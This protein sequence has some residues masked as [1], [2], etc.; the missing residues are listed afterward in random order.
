MR[1]LN[2]LLHYDGTT[3]WENILILLAALVAGFLLH[4]YLVKTKANQQF[5]QSLKEWENKHRQ[6]ENE[7][8]A[9]KSTI[10]SSEKTSQKSVTELSGRVK[11]LEGDIRALSDEKNKYQHQLQAKEDELKKYSSQVVD[12]EDRLKTLREEKLK[13]EAE[14]NQKLKATREELDKAAAWES[15]VKSAEEEAQR[16]RAA[17]GHAE[18]KKLEAELRLKATADYAGKVVPLEQEL[19][20]FKEKYSAL[21]AEASDRSSLLDELRDK[22]NLATTKMEKDQGE[23]LQLK[24]DLL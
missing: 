3:A 10:N 2:I 8:K 22:L 12:L 7:F 4:Q 19:S 23:I 13:T 18:R 15:K 16:S 21:E 11:A 9:Y 24:D 5:H 17:I 20:A 14:W 1:L 6:L